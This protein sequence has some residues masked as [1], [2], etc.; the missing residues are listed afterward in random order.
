MEKFEFLFG[1]VLG[2]RILK[3]TDDLSKTLQLSSLTA[4]EG[5]KL[6]DLTCQT[7]E[8]IRNV[9]GFVK[10]YLFY[11]QNLTHVLDFTAS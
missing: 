3:H 8:K 11:T 6:A 2:A 4:A 9:T 1:L 10:R 7:L 5:Q